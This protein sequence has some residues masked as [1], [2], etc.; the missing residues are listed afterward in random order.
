MIRVARCKSRGTIAIDP[1]V[2]S[3]V[4]SFP[5]DWVLLIRDSLARERL[6]LLSFVARFRR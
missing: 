1:S 5:L 3:T 6:L 4:A 2:H